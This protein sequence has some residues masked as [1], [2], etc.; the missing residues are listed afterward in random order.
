MSEEV[1][2]PWGSYTN[3]MDEE[4]TK[5]KKIVIKSGQAP[6]YQYHFKRSEIWVIVKGTAEVRIDDNTMLHSVGDIIRI[7]TEAKHQITNVGNEDVVF[8]EIQLGEYFGEDDIVR[9][10][11]KYGRV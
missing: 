11:D 4:Y 1:V 5:V 2:K 8:V 9:L 6:S 3:L 10:E 7:P